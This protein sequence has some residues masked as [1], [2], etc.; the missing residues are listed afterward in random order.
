M[1]VLLTGV[2]NIVKES[3]VKLALDQLSGKVKFKVLSF[4]DF[5]EGSETSISEL[6]TLKG[7]QK[8]L[9]ENI[10]L[11]LLKAKPKEH[12]IINGYFTVRTKLGFVPVI[13]KESIDIFKPDIIVHI[14]VNPLAL[15]GKIPS[16]ED[17]LQNQSVEKFCAMLFGA[18]AS[19][20]IKVIVTGPDGARKG[21]DEL[22]RLLK[23]VLVVE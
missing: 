15:Q 20:G 7:I 5:V 2:Q 6:N 18:L 23:D 14:D 1:N 9:R 16:K 12:V 10:Q 11:K 3:V 22:Y 8:K 13:T 4:S 17:F 19:S 21:A